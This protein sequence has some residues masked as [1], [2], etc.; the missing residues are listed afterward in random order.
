MGLSACGDDEEASVEPAAFDLESCLTRWDAAYSARFNAGETYFLPSL[1]NV[2]DC[3]GL[4]WALPN[5]PAGNLN[6]LVQGDSFARF[7]PHISGT[8][9]FEVQREGESVGVSQTLEVVNPLLR[10]FHNYNYFP[11]PSVATLVGSELWVAGV[12]SP[13]IART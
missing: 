9:T 5:S 11:A 10:P 4:T 7:T 3:A 6:A 2:D 1:S 12:Y 13:E 8:Y